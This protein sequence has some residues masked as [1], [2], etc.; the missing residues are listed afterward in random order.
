MEAKAYLEK[1]S[2]LDKLIANKLKEIEQWKSIAEGTS[3]S[4]NADR[5]QTS[6]SLH[7]MEDAVIRIVD[8][9]NETR[10]MIDSYIAMKQDVISVIESLSD[11]TLYDI[12]HKRYIQGIPLTEVSI[13]LDLSWESTKRK[14][15]KALRLVQEILNER[16]SNK[17]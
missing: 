12:L 6:V 3:I 17:C 11:A 14:H 9:E 16:Y 5:V 4:S 10:E 13:M 1:V 8:L 15:K 7:K 2:K